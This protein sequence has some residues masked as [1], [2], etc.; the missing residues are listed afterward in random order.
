MKERINRRLPSA[1]IVIALLAFGVAI[2]GGAYAAAVKLKPGSVKTKTIKN[3]AVK[4]AKIANNAV[5]APKVANNAVTAPKLAKGAVTAEKL[6][7]CPAGTTLL[8]GQCFETTAHA[9][10][11]WFNATQDC[12]T[13][14]G[15]LPL[16]AELNAIRQS[17]GI[18]LGSNGGGTANMG[19]EQ[20]DGDYGTVDDAGVVSVAIGVNTARPYRCVLPRG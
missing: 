3:N 11:T 14:G 7:D 10:A 4:T 1:A 17:P 19:A 8:L 15:R 16:S 9:A 18:D 12:G 20:I 5:T 2:G 6:G 13:R